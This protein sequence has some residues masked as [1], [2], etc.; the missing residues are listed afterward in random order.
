MEISTSSYKR[1]HKVL[2][3]CSTH[4]IVVPGSTPFTITARTSLRR[5]FA[6]GRVLARIK[7]DVGHGKWL[8]WLK[9]N[10]TIA[11]RQLLNE[12]SASKYLR[13]AKKLPKDMVDD[14][15]TIEEAVEW[16]KSVE[17]SDDLGRR[18]IP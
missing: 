14:F 3:S 18:S 7:K 12:R 8:P 9:E 17:D 15:R 4:S 13:I 10:T 6:L 11:G 16:I 1:I 5:A 2:T